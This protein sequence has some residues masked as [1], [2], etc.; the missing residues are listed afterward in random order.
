MDVILHLGVHR[1]GTTT[2]Q[3]YLRE[4]RDVLSNAGVEYWGPG[5]TR[6]GLFDGVIPKPMMRFQRRDP[7]SRAEGRIKLRLDG[8]RAKG[9][10]HLLVSEE[11][12]MGSMRSNLLEGELYPAAGERISRFVRAFGE[13]VDHIT[14]TIRSP[15]RYWASVMNFLVAKGQPVPSQRKM[16]AIVGSP[17]TWRQ[18]ITDLACAAPDATICVV[19]F[20]STYAN[21]QTLMRSG[22]RLPVALQGGYEWLNKSPGLPQLR[23]LLIERGQD[24]GQLPEGTQNWMPFDA[25]Q[26]AKFQET[27]SDDLFWLA[28]GANGLATLTEEVMP[29]GRGKAHHAGAMRGQTDDEKGQLEGTG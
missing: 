9:R 22:A 16:D 2:F 5:M 21:P 15:E 26:I 10:S 18:V 4:R 24:D 29:A 6:K 7:A 14:L 17:R 20:E 8:L 23:R 19:P 25:A 3:S 1:T 11:N 27:Y 12:M 28:Q 13:Q